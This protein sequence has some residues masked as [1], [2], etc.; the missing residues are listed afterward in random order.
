M[1]NQ[2]RFVSEFATSG[3]YGVTVKSDWVP[4]K[5]MAVEAAEASDFDEWQIQRV[6]VTE[7]SAPDDRGNGGGS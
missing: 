7:S 4:Y 3:G 6:F 5:D 1:D 2:F